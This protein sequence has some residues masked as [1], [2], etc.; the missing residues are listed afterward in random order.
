VTAIDTTGQLPARQ[1]AASLVAA[2]AML[3]VYLLPAAAAAKPG[4]KPANAAERAGEHPETGLASWYGAAHQGHRTASGERFDRRKLT[5]AHPFLPFSTMLRVT[6][7]GSGRSVL[8]RVND[9]GPN[10]PG[11][12]IDLSEAAARPIGMDRTGVV[13]IAIT[14]LPRLDNP[15]D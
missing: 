1:R 5:A 10:H 4:V 12:V 8:A 6:E 14:V 13:R 15:D 9:R 11:R 3:S 2:T 7:L